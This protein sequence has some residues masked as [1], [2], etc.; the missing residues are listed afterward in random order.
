MSQYMRLKPAIFSLPETLSRSSEDWWAG[1]ISGR[2]AQAWLHV[3]KHLSIIWPALL[4]FVGGC[5]HPST[6]SGR[7]LL[8][9]PGNMN[10]KAQLHHPEDVILVH[11]LARTSRSMNKIGRVLEHRGYRVLKF[12]YPSTRHPIAVLSENYLNPFIRSHCS[13]SSRQIHFVTHSMG[14]ILVRFYLSRRPLPELG[15][16]VMLAPPNQGSEVTDWLRHWWFYR[17]LFGP[18][19]QQLGTDAASL[20][21]QLGP[22][23]YEVGIIAG[24]RS[25]NPFNSLKITGPDDG[26]VAVERTKVAG[27]QD[28]RR[29]HSCHT[30]MMCNNRVLEH[31]VHFLQTGHFSPT[32]PCS[33]NS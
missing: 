32:S 29:L 10:V 12:G 19:G 15:R 24:D 14:G 5:P 28:F 16:V 4:M 1:H 20:P 8:N 9:K 26:K 13:E 23:T 30:F 2:P 18:A 27:M 33:E 6:V 21:M 11:G 31:I 7:R 3:L 17:W 22:V 25:I